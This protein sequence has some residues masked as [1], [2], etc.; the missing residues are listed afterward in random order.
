MNLFLL[1]QSVAGQTADLGV[2]AAAPVKELNY[3]D[4]ALLGGWIMVPLLLLSLVAVYIFV[5]R[6][7]ALRKA[8][9]EDANF[10]NRIKDYIHDGKID[11]ALSLCQA[12]EYP[13]ARMVEKGISRLGRPLSD[14]N[15]AIENVGN[16]EVSRLEK[17]LPVLASVA[18]G[19]PMIGFLGTVI[20]MIQSFWQMANSG[21]NIEVSALAGGIY[22]A[23]VTTVAGLI[24]GIIA[25]F[26][27]NLLVS[28][29]EQVVFNIEA[30]SM[31]FMDIL[32]EPAK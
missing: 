13:I 2:A 23:L 17:G 10:M 18:G 1:A 26:A 3:I 12:S 25:Y 6:F 5:D 14:V 22:T 27:Y 32:N 4:L 31:E 21:N 16:L 28:K 8:A 9:Q 24:V 15:A 29:V 20:G 19:A 11:S 30:R 7:L